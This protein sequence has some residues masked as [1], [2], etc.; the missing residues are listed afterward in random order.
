MHDFFATL[1]ARRFAT[2]YPCARKGS[3]VYHLHH[4]A[5]YQ[6]VGEPDSRYR[7]RASVERAIE[8]LMVLDA[9]LMKSNLTWLAT[10]REKVAYCRQDRKLSEEH[11]PRLIFEGGGSRTVRYFPDKL[12][13]GLSDASDEVAIL[14]L[15]TEPTARVFRTFLESHRALLQ[16]LS[17]WRLVLVVPRVFATAEPAHR[18]AVTDLCAAPPRPAPGPP[19][20]PPRPPP[21]IE[22]PGLRCA[23]AMLAPSPPK[24]PEPSGSVRTQAPSSR[25]HAAGGS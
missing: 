2:V 23:A 6:A 25:R 11:L 20:R 19:P 5:L 10:E 24:L 9:V 18:A 13:L 21:P 4:K 8:R 12:P 7:R 16:R 14:Y 3:H 17:K 22:T 15:V 1:T